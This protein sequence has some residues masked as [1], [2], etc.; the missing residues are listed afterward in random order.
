M[1]ARCDQVDAARRATLRPRR[2]GRH[3]VVGDRHRSLG[4]GRPD[5]HEVAIDGR[6]GQRGGVV[7]VALEAV[8]A[9]GRDDEDA[10]LPGLLGRVGE[11][12][13]R[14]GLGA[15][16]AVRQVDDPDVQ[17]VVVAMLDDPVDRG[18]DLADVHPT[19]GDAD[20]DRHDPGVRG[21][22]AIGRRRRIRVR[23]R[24][25]GVLAGDE[26]GHERPVAVGVEVAQ[27]GRLG[28]EREVGSVDDLAR[29]GQALDPADTRVDD[30]DVDAV[31]G[32]ARVPPR[33]RARV[34]GRVGHR[35]HVGSGV[36]A[37]GQRGGRD[38]GRGQERRRTAR[39]RVDRSARY[40]GSSRG[41]PGVRSEGTDPLS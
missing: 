4:V 35:V 40:R 11:R 14:G 37:A 28:L 17:V 24:E 15:V 1:R 30:R 10:R 31:A 26:P 34:R 25:A 21:H 38:D 32:E 41:R 9:A 27:V 7:H 5:R 22:P 12:V 8:V 2:E 6:V 19:V 13:D 23:R 18:D 16:G 39:R 20:L 33:R 29:R 3:R 36:V